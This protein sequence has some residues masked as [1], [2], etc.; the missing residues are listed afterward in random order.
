MIRGKRGAMSTA[1]GIDREDSTLLSQVVSAIGEA[2]FMELLAQFSQPISGCSS[3]VVGLF[4]SGSRPHHLFDTLRTR[5]AATTVS[6]YIDGP[7]LLD[8]FYNLMTEGA[9]EGVYRLLDIAPDE[10]TDSEY[11][12]VYYRRTRLVEEIALLVRL[13]AD[14]HLL[15]SFGARESDGSKPDLSALGKLEPLLGALCRKHWEIWRAREPEGEAT[16]ASS[17]DSAYRNFGR[18]LLTDRERE[19]MMLLLKGHSGK[20]M[21][22]VLNI[23]PETIKIHRRNLYNKIDVGTQSELFSVFLESLA[24]IPIGSDED[25]LERYQSV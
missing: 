14:T 22:R 10:F 24:T 3:T 23:S 2:D 9:P 1:T 4:K 6:P 19:V 20:S 13:D 12:N 8:P 5:D 15:V 7:Y 25:P 21:A 17:L 11:Y 18:D 16:F